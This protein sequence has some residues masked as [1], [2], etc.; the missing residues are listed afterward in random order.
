MET[1]KQPLVCIVTVNWNGGDRI[2]QCIESLVKI[3]EYDNYK[4]IIS[5][6][7]STDGSCERIEKDFPQVEILRLKENLGWTIG[8]NSGWTYAFKKYDPDYMVDMNDDLITVQK[9]WLTIM[10]NCLE[11]KE[12]RVI[13]G[14]KL[15]FP[16]NRVQLLYMD[17]VPK[18][19]EEKD[20]GQ[21]DYIKEVSG[22]GGANMLIKRS[23]INKM[24]AVDENYFYGPDDLDYCLRA[25]KLGYKI[26][27]NGFSKSI[28]I[29]SFS[30]LSAS[31]DFIYKH[32][33][34]GGMLVTFRHGNAKEILSIILHELA[35]A[36]I[37]RK[38]PFKKTSFNNIY[39]HPTCLK[40]LWY[41]F[42]S[43]FRAIWNI[44]KV[45]TEHFINE[46]L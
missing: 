3:T 38:D 21:F 10:V 24:G 25:K 29:G 15:L 42:P 23:L 1:I 14:N 9:D 43:F 2:Y 28:H 34:Y 33:S 37:T 46:R 12:E 27:Y 44:N 19:Y 4:I 30:Y 45:N 5:D 36:F 41:F 22:V 7:G 16:D 6:N 26:I 40:R 17:R 13:C 20:N 32:Y 18:E 8:I 35:R 31:K 11:E 39:F